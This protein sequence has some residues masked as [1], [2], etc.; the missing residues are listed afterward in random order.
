MLEAL[1]RSFEDHQKLPKNQAL[2]DFRSNFHQTLKTHQKL[3]DLRSIGLSEVS[4]SDSK[5]TEDGTFQKTSSL[6]Q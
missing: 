5:S 2:K 1:E 3:F 6:S 4:F